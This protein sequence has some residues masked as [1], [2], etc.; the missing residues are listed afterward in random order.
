[1]EIKEVIIENEK[2]YLKKNRF[3]W[4][5]VHPI[6]IDGKINWKNLISGGNWWN[7]LI[8]L[9]IILIILGCVNEYSNAVRTANECLNYTQ[10]NYIPIIK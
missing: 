9:I 8:I 6:K 7:L 1:M 4:K 10:I 3:G 2:I 5:V